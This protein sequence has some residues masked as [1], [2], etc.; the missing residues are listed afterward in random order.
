MND[1]ALEAMKAPLGVLDV[2]RVGWKRGP[3]YSS[4]MAVLKDDRIIMTVGGTVA[5]ALRGLAVRLVEEAAK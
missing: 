3:T 2:K 4:A 5:S 1:E